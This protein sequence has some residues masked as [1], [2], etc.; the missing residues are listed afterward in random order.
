VRLDDG[1]R[2]AGWL[3]T[4]TN[5]ATYH[6]QAVDRLPDAVEANGWADDGTVEAFEVCAA[7][8]AIGVQWH[9]EVHDGLSLF[10]ALVAASC[11]WRDAE[12]PA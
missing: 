3:G 4:R 2:I 8:W 5:V 10:S 1:S 12:V 11:A 9:P 6:H 7:T